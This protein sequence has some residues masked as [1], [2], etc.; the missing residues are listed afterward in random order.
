MITFVRHYRRTLQIGLFLVIAAFIASL[1]V[2]GSMSRDSAQSTN[3]AVVNGEPISVDRYQRRYQNWQRFYAQMLR[4]RFSP[5]VA[6][7][8]GLP[9]QVI[10]D[11]IQEELTVQR[12]R[13]EGLEVTDEELTAHIVGIPAFQEGG[14]FTMRRYEERLRG[15]GYT[16]AS[17][18]SEQRRALTRMRVQQAVREG[19]RVSDAE[20][21]QLWVTQRQ[22]VRAA[23]ALVEL[24]PLVRTATATDEEL[25]AYLKDHGTQFRQ[26]ERRRIQYLAFPPAAFKPTISDADVEKYYA[27]H[28]A[29][30]TEPRQM[31]AAH[32]L[33]RVGETGGSEAEDQARAKVAEAIRRVKAGEDFAKVAKEVSQD[34]GSA[35]RG[36][37]LGFIKA[38]E[39]VPEFEKAV[40]T[41]K[42][43]EITAEP[44]RTPF[45]FHAIKALEIREGG[46][47]PLKDVAKGIREKLTG[48]AA[49]RLARER[50]EEVRAKLLGAPDFMAAARAMGLTPLETTIARRERALAT[51]AD[52]LEEAAFQVTR[53]GISTLVRTPAGWV[54]LK[55]ADAMPAGVPPLAEIKDQ[56]ATAVKRQKAETQAMDRG[57]QLLGEARTGDLAEAARKVGASY[58]ETPRFSRTKAAERLPGD[59]M[60]AAL[61][62]PVG[63]LTDAIKTPQG[64]YVLKTLERVS[65]D[66]GALAGE[67]DK[68]AAELLARKQGVAWES[69]I[70]AARSKA[71]IEISSHPPPARRG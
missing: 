3:V 1:F 39:L 69:W 64:V 32:I 40:F 54:V 50:A 53:G 47:K 57:R 11:L 61:R 20:L 33:V 56:V 66:M 22:E 19:V 2:F 25:A 63:Q 31:R 34:Q 51:A 9:Q 68:L 59:A 35:S 28:A 4:E 44:V 48:E 67:R 49:D 41:L 24:G 62:T 42:P 16:K 18:E 21:E 60:L 29:E 10:E 26:P 23:W 71:K 15:L 5:E 52:P 45:G 46:K 43:G 13:S 37:D 8:M 6:E 7:Q 30:F 38:G 55:Q 27:E 17:F 58:G 36:G 65:P 14:R 12:A 70:Q